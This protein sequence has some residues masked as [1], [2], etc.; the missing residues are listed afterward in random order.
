MYYIIINCIIFS[1]N[2]TMMKLFNFNNTRV[3]SNYFES[4]PKMTFF[5]DCNAFRAS[6]LDP[7]TLSN[8]LPTHPSICPYIHPSTHSSIYPYIHPPILPSA[9][10]STHPPILPS[11]HT[12]TH[13]SFHLPIHPPT[14]PSIYPYIHPST[15][16]PFHLFIHPSIIL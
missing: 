14:H 8:Y 4:Y 6:D 13:P 15:H 2:I 3:S 11:T 16:P 7:P 12:S 1:P 10:T 5:F 9:H